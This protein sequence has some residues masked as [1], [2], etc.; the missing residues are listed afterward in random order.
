VRISAAIESFAVT[1]NDVVQK[2][3]GN[4]VADPIAA[5][6]AFLGQTRGIRFCSR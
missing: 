5:Q 1:L 4:Q 3:T 2:C 6:S